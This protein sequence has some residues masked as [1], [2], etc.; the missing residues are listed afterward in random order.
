M[1]GKYKS[2]IFTF[3]EPWPDYQKAF[4]R[5]TKDGRPQAS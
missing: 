5:L 1:A 4:E 3:Q 2:Q